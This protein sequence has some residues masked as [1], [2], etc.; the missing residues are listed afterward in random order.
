MG[1]GYGDFSFWNRAGAVSKGRFSYCLQLPSAKAAGGSPMFLRFGT[2]VVEPSG[3]KSTPLQ[4]F[5]DRSTYY[6]TLEGITVGPQRLDVDP[7][8]FQLTADG[9]GGCIIDSGAATSYIVSEAYGK[10]L[11]AVSNVIET[12][13]TNVRTMDRP[14]LGLRLCYERIADPIDIKVPIITYH[15]ANNADLVIPPPASF[16]ISQAS[17]GNAMV[18]LMYLES[19]QEEHNSVTY[20]GAYQQMNQRII[21]DNHVGQL[22]FAQADCSMAN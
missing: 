19:T 13:N 9:R 17:S 7:S 10:F 11:D 1:M 20:L 16:V 5:Q 4:R 22:L 6:L 15:F 3:M 12:S 8:M 21:Y 18:C 2:D 14:E